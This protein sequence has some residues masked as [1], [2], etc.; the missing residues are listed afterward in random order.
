MSEDPGISVFLNKDQK[1][2]AAELQMHLGSTI[3]YWEQLHHFVFEQYPGAEE[4]WSYFSKNYGWGY[5]IKD[6]RRAIIYMSP[7]EGYFQVTMLFGPRALEHIYA[8]DLDPWI[9]KTLEEGKKYPEGKVIHIPVR[10][11][12][13]IKSIQKLIKVK[14]AFR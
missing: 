3:T 11:N 5:R 12:T 9:R 14:L 8:S 1:P 7:Y 2:D 6:K 4:L 10:D 13:W